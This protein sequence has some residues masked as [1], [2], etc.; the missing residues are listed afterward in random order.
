[1]TTDEEI[2]R[3]LIIKKKK[4]RG[5]IKYAFINE[6]VSELIFDNDIYIG[7][8]ISTDYFNFRG[9]L[10]EEVHIGAHKFSDEFV[11]YVNH[12]A[13]RG[14]CYK[15]D[16]ITDR[17]LTN[18]GERKEYRVLTFEDVKNRIYDMTMNLFKGEEYIDEP[19]TIF[20]C[21]G[22][23]LRNN[24]YGRSLTKFVRV[25]F[26]AYCRSELIRNTNVYEITDRRNGDRW[27]MRSDERDKL[28][29]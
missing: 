14:S 7:G 25:Y 19:W 13:E 2:I 5:S 11:N 23:A 17:Y 22:I 28:Y 4:H 10:V 15:T 8:T 1:M 16:K 29:R 18:I 12:G 27:W 9:Y 3:K 6:G 20:T 24:Y 21:F 26:S